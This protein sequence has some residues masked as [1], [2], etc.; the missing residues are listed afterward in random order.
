MPNVNGK[1]FPYTSAGKSAAK[2]AMGMMGGGMPMKPT[3]MKNGG[4]A[5]KMK[6]GGAAMKP[7]GNCGLFGRK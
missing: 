1:K 2:K 7:M 5:K 6:D 3:M 4:K